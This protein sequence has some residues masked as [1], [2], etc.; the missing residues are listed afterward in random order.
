MELY[1]I[2]GLIFFTNIAFWLHLKAMIGKLHDEHTDEI[3]GLYTDYQ[4]EINIIFVRGGR[5]FIRLIN[6]IR[7]L[8]KE[9]RDLKND[10]RKAS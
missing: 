2:L 5:L 10:Q 4:K 9:N 3:Q 6:E 7:H 8:K 1:I